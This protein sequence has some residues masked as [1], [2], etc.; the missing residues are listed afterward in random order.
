MNNSVCGPDGCC[1]ECGEVCSDRDLVGNQIEFGFPVYWCNVCIDKSWKRHVSDKAQRFWDEH[2]EWSQATFGLDS[3]RGPLGPLRHLEKE[4]R[5]A[6][7][8]LVLP[9]EDTSEKLELELADCLFLIFDAARRA[10]MSLDKLLDKCFEK[11]EI[12]K[13]RKWKTPNENGVVEHEQ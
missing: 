6:Y 12:N 4:A 9:D 11:L 5:E 1:C 2:S 13:N 10:G 3:E 7:L 8:E